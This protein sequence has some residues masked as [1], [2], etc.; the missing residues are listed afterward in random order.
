MTK[1]KLITFTLICIFI[2]LDCPANIMSDFDGI[3]QGDIDYLDL[4]REGI[5]NE[6]YIFKNNKYLF[7]STNIGHN[8]N[9]KVIPIKFGFSDLPIVERL[10]QITDTGKYFVN[11]LTINKKEFFQTCNYSYSRENESLFLF[12]QEYL[13]ILQLPKSTQLVLFS[14]SLTDSINYAREFLDYDICSIQSN[15]CQL[16]DSLLNPIMI[17]PQ[18]DI[19]VVRNTEGELLHVEY[20]DESNHYITGYIRRENLQ[21][22]VEKEDATSD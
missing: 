13:K 2:H 1:I 5:E 22:V 6:Y 10:E 20:E 12:N 17:I 15:E 14:K 7:V 4:E 21:F 19:V 9:Y 11:I 18:G 8:S 16:L 3:W